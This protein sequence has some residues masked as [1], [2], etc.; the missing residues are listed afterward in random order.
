MKSDCISRRDTLRLMKLGALMTAGLGVTKM[1]NAETGDPVI[2]GG[3][4]MGDN[5]MK[6]SSDLAKRFKELGIKENGYGLTVFKFFRTDMVGL[7]AM[8]VQGDLAEARN[9]PKAMLMF[10]VEIE[11]VR[12]P[13]QASGQLGNFEI[14]D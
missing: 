3:A 13:I 4:E 11:G 10:K 12:R 8:P 9:D 1:V 14:Q 2:V 7:Y 5:T 6:I